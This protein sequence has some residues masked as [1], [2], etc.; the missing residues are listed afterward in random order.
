MGAHGEGACT[1]WAGG[2]VQVRRVIENCGRA[3][4]GCV[5]GDRINEEE[6]KVGDW[7]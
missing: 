1:G 7:G 2:A 4:W 6:V 5:F 3:W